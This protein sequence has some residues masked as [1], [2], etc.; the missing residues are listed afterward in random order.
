MEMYI[1]NLSRFHL[2]KGAQDE[3]LKAYLF[4]L[5]ADPRHGP[6]PYAYRL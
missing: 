1:F 5:L 4:G 3:T 2:P 6:C